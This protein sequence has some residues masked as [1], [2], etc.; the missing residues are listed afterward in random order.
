MANFN[1]GSFLESATTAGLGVYQTVAIEKAKAKAAKYAAQAAIARAQQQ[2]Y[3]YPP[4]PPTPYPY[5]PPAQVPAQIPYGDD[6]VLTNAAYTPM[7]TQANV[8]SG[9]VGAAGRAI[10]SRLPALVMRLKTIW[11]TMAEAGV[12]ALGTGL[13]ANGISDGAAGPYA[14]ASDNRVTGVMRGDI[15]AI[16]RV[17]RQGRRLQKVLRMAGFGHHRRPKTRTRTRYVRVGG[18]RR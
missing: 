6:M 1:F 7:L 10:A 2:G 14:K 17:R 8:L 18:A 5:P 3:G 16:K 15:K 13:L 9:A 4:P 11:P 12:I